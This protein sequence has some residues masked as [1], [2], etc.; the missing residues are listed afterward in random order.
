ML[1]GFWLLILTASRISFAAYLLG[2]TVVT[3]L[4]TF[5]KG[6]GW[7]ISRWFVATFLSLLLMLSF[8]DLSDRFLRLVRVS[9]RLGGFRAMLTSPAGRPPENVA[10]L[11]NNLAAVTS[12][13]DKPPTPIRPAEVTGKEQP[14]L[15]AEKTASGSTV[16]VERQRTYSKNAVLFDLSTGIRLDAT[17]PR[18]ID[19]FKT[20]PLTGKGYATLTKVNIEDFTEAESTDSDYLRALGETGLLG[21]LTFFGT[22]FLMAYL[23]FKSLGGIRDNFLYALTTGFIGVL[24][25]LLLN[26]TYIDIFIASKVAYVFW[27]VAGLTMGTLYL[28]RAKIKENMAPLKL[29]FNLETYKENFLAFLKSDRFWLGLLLI[30]F[31]YLRLLRPVDFKIGINDPVADWH[32]WRQSDTSAVTREFVR[33][34]RINWLHPMYNDL[35]SVPSGLPNPNGYRFVEFPLYNAIAFYVRSFVPELNVEGAGRVATILA[36]LSTLVFVFLI[37]RKLFSRRIAYLAAALYGLLPYSIFYGRSILPDPTMVAFSFAALW[38][39]LNFVETSRYRFLLLATVSAAAALLVKPC[40]IFLLLPLLY[41]WL[42]GFG[43]NWRKWLLL[44]LLFAIIAVPLLLWRLW[45]QN[46]PEGI[47]ASGWLLNGDGIRFKGAFWFWLFADRIGRLIL[48]Y[49]GLV[50]LG[51]GLARKLPGKYSLFPLVLF[52][53]SV[54]YLVVFATGNVRHDYYQILIVPALTIL[55][56]LG[57]DLLLFAKSPTI[58]PVFAKVTGVLALLFMFGFNFYHVRDLYNINHPEIVAAGK[59]LDEFTDGRFEKAK[60]V[61]PYDGDTAFLYATDRKGWPIMEG[62]IEDMIKKGAHFYVSVRFDSLTLDILTNSE[63]MEE[64][65]AFPLRPR[66]PYRLIEKTDQYVIVQLVPDSKLPR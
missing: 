35:S 41:F 40:A 34:G 66:K 62:S 63:T 59:R 65:E 16:Y 12:L 28:N 10:L 33:D 53:S 38:A 14:L 58:H 46:F 26:A 21:F 9:E 54:A 18:A 6:I 52:F 7:G 48:G 32:S 36:N 30:S 15:V 57:L 5:K 3:F 11:E 39:G 13:S 2:L 64:V 51:F 20:N 4:W 44:G 27:G 24:I 55:A 23:A 47:P 22:L 1:G 25:G 50:L 61:A 19:G 31:F 17:W 42:V 43:L 45:I 60:V 29:E 8:G 56:A 49:W 37:C